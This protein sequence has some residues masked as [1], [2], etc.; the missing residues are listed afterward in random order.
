MWTIPPFAVTFKVYLF[1]VTNPYEVM[2]GGKPRVQEI[3]P[4]VFDEYKT[5]FGLEDNEEEDTVEYD[6]K[7]TWV[8]R[9]DLT[10]DLTGDEVIT[11]PHLFVMVS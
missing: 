4:Y 6:M 3:G 10:G 9:P 8:F 7:N 1:N 11:I 2:N 5:K